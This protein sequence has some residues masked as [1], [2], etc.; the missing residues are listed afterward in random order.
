MYLEYR[1]RLFIN[2]YVENSFI[3]TMLLLNN[4]G[5]KLFIF[6]VFYNI[7]LSSIIYKLS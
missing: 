2:E 1:P 4:V 7:S 5:I 6:N 3:M